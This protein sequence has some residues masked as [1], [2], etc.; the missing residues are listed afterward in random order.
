MVGMV[1]DDAGVGGSFCRV[2]YLGLG[3][4]NTGNEIPQTA[5]TEELALNRLALGDNMYISL[6]VSFHSLRTGEA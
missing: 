5:G 4:G 6:A 1:L 3:H 2:V